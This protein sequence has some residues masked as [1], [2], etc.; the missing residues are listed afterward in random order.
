MKKEIIYSTTASCPHC[1]QNVTINLWSDD[2]SFL[3]KAPQLKDE[4]KRQGM[5][6]HWFHNH[7]ICARCG[8]LIKTGEGSWALSSRVEWAINETY[9][10]WTHKNG[11]EVLDVHK[12]CTRKNYQK[13]Q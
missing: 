3:K 8:E 9:V 10:S 6:S 4:V 11:L 2:P 13:F 1:N 5:H 12:T 7:R